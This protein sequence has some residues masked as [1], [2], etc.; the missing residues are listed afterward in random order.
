M[1]IVDLSVL[2][3]EDTPVYPGDPKTKVEPAGVFVKDGFNDHFISMGTHVGTHVDA[4]MHMLEDGRGLDEIPV[5]Q[6]VGQGRYI[7][8]DGSFDIQKIKNAGIQPGEI[9]LFHTGMSDKYH[10]ADYF[11]QYPAM[12]KEIADYLVEQ[13][14]KMVGLD[15]G[16]AD[17]ADGFPIHKALLDGNV[18]IIENLTNLAALAGKSFM[19]YALP[20]KLSVDGSPAR[21]IAVLPEDA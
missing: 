16:S 2:I 1:Q 12:S 15:T 14:V 19:V 11:E 9:V 7:K 10:D 21:V 5:G 18:L 4:P 3:N 20:L 17:N 8:V 6:F 13:K